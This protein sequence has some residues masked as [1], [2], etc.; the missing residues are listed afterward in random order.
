MNYP[1]RQDKKTNKPESERK[2]GT[3]T[4]R[5]ERNQNRNNII[6]G[7]DKIGRDKETRE[8][9]AETHKDNRAEMT[10]LD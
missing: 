1:Y 10:A 4:M 8:S 2:K 3:Q 6:I 7:R 5:A 9:K